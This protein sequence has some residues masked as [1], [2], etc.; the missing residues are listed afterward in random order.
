M[1]DKGPGGG[2]VVYDAGARQEWGRYLEV[3]PAGWS[4]NPDDPKDLWCPTSSAAY[5]ERITGQK[6]SIGSGELNTKIIIAACG[7]STAAGRAADY[8]GGG[9][10]DWFLP[11]S[12]EIEFLYNMRSEIG[13]F[14]MGSYWS[15]SSYWTSSQ[16]EKTKP[17]TTD[18]YTGY[19]QQALALQVIVGATGSTTP[20]LEDSMKSVS[21]SI[22]PMRAF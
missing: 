9:L 15:T 13:G 10:D 18:S 21:R 22:R 4:G 14:D 2:V 7:Q 1:F 11:S 19:P 8:R 5:E 16:R 17:V 3:A 12:G 6:A 20:I